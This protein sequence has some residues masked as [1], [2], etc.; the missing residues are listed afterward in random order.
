MAAANWTAIEQ[1][2]QACVRRASGLE[3]VVWTDQDGTRPQLPYATI[4]VDPPDATGA[5]DEV[6]VSLTPGQPAGAELTFETCSQAEFDLRVQVFTKTTRGDDSACRIATRLRNSLSKQSELAILSAAGVA[7]VDRGPVQNLTA[8]L[9]TRSEGRAALDVR[10]RTADGT[11]ETE[12]YIEH[13]KISINL[14]Q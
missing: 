11:T 12:T 10:L 9:E 2:L 5:R 13:V 14:S 4:R 8:L 6:R 3:R 1:E 7:V